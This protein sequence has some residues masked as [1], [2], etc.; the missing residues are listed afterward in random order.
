MLAGAESLCVREVLL[1][2]VRQTRK[3]WAKRD[4]GRRVKWSQ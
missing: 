3:K 1:P 4:W 2:M